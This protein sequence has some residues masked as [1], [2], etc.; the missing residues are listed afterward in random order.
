M[1]IWCQQ[2]ITNWQLKNQ[3]VSCQ[4]VFFFFII[5]TAQPAVVRLKSK[6]SKYKIKIS[7]RILKRE[8]I[9]LKNIYFNNKNAIDHLKNCHPQKFHLFLLS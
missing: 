4:Q 3:F 2:K 9:K 1:I 5:E 7:P 8:K 6:Y